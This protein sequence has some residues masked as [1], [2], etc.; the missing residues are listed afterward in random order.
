MTV[1]SSSI[2][3]GEEEENAAAEVTDEAMLATDSGLARVGVGV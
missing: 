1:D 2:E 3:P